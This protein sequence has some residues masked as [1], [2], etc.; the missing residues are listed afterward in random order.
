MIYEKVFVFLN[1]LE[2]TM[3]AYV[4]YLL[5]TYSLIIA[6][7]YFYDLFKKINKYIKNNSR[8]Y[9]LYN[10]NF[11][12]VVKK[13]LYFAFI[14]NLIYGLF[15]LMTGIYYISYWLITLAIYYL[16]LCFM[17]ISI[18]RSVKNK[19]GENLDKEYKI[20]K[21]TGIILLFLNII[22]S[23]IIILI[24][25]QN[26]EIVNF[27]N[28]IYIIALYDFYLII[29]AFINV[30]KYRSNK[31]PSLL[32]SKCIN[33]TVAMISI[34][35]LEVAMIYQFGDNDLVFLNIMMQISGFVVVIINSLMAIYIIYKA[36][37]YFKNKLVLN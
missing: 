34:I 10:N 7:I 32:A 14:I 36:N 22:L 37:K 3:I 6:C 28:L 4:S 17:R 12:S 35:S 9:K 18:I 20:L 16:L 2:N 11:D 19:F 21:L 25:H 33:L 27:N 30:F 31:S 23:G 5:S 1:S 26:H 15:K 8:L 24:N 29:T 13:S